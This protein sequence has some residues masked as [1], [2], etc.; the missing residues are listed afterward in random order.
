MQ[1]LV[2]SMLRV[3]WLAVGSRPEE[4]TGVAGFW[5]AEATRLPLVY[6]AAYFW[7]T[8]TAIYLLLRR[9]IDEQQAD[10]VFLEKAAAD[11]PAE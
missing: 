5:W 6:H 10:E 1:L 7:C 2:R 4:L 8:V 11:Q 9:D 3:A